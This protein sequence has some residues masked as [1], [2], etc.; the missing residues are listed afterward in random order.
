MKLQLL[1]DLQQEI[2]RLFIAGSKFARDDSRLQKQIQ[3]LNKLG[4]KAP[5]FNKLAAYVDDLLHT[6]PAESAD[7]LMAVSTL[8]YSILYT[9]GETVES[10]RKEKKQIPAIDIRNVNTQYSYLQLKP[11]IEALTG[12]HSGRLEMLKDAFERKIFE[13]SRTWQYLD[14]ALADKYP[15]L[16]D[17][18]EKTIIPSVG[19]PLIPFL[20]QHFRYEDKTEH[21]RRLRLLNQMKYKEIPVMTTKILSESLPSLQAGA[22]DILGENTQNESLIIQLADDRNKIV[23]EAAYSSLAALNTR[24]SLEKLANVFTKNKNKT[25]HLPAII[26]ALASTSLP[27][28]FQDIYNQIAKS[29]ED[30]ASLDKN[31]EDKIL[32]EKLNLFY[33][34]LGALINKDNE[35]VIGLLGKIMHDENYNRLLA[36]RKALLET[37]AYH[38]SHKIIAILHTFF[39]DCQMNFYQSHLSDAFDAYWK[40]PLWNSYFFMAFDIYSKEQFYAV[41]NNPVKTGRISINTVHKTFCNK[42]EK[43]EVPL[44]LTDKID[45][46]WI[47]FF[48]AFLMK[49]ATLWR[50][51]QEMVLEIVHT[52]ER[53]E[54]LKFNTLLTELTQKL[55]P[56]ECI[57][58]FKIIMERKIDNRFEI[59]YSVIKTLRRNSYHYSFYRLKNV[60]FWN[61][62]PSEYKSR[63][64]Q[65]YEQHNVPIF[66]EIVDE[67]P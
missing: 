62:F 28:C 39:K 54:S 49:K 32:T 61:Q 12:V 30:F 37:T 2:N 63:F 46:R 1:Y 67:I 8:L 20:V 29:F 55:K 44:P 43:G 9:Q 66:G 11:V 65:L 27:F 7:K 24:A 52:Y 21:L 5:V 15:E 10:G 42:R 47:D 19:T 26:S 64:L 34:H 14:L 51:E 3:Q 16:A 35:L 13:D 25:D 31:T 50:T 41:F 40:N 17:Y 23:R 22:I 60:N 53:N 38:I 59:I 58:I 57:E 48:Y 6:D 18:V 45:V 4:E 56:E 33:I 36:V